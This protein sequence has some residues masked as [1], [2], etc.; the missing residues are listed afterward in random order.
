MTSP[1]YRRLRRAAPCSP[2]R[3]RFMGAFT[4]YGHGPK[5]KEFRNCCAHVVSHGPTTTIVQSVSSFERSL[6]C[7]NVPSSSIGG[8]G[9]YSFCMYV[10][11][12]GLFLGFTDIFKA[13]HECNQCLSPKL[14]DTAARIGHEALFISSL[15]N[16]LVLIS[17]TP[18]RPLR[19]NKMGA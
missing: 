12:L 11:R 19:K 9:P 14:F 1:T 2:S 17:C 6:Q 10:N 7:A 13:R 16:L 4:E 8:I 3:R 5:V 18:F 15:F